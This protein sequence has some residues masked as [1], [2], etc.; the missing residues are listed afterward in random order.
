MKPSSSPRALLAIESTAIARMGAEAARVD[1]L[2]AREVWA[3]LKV[4]DR[5]G[6]S[7]ENAKHCVWRDGFTPDL[8]A[9]V[10]RFLLGKEEVD[11]DILRSR[12]DIDRATWIRGARPSWSDA[13]P[14]RLR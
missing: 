4:P 7:E 6:A 11:T 1:A 13:L 12:F 9:Y 2:A 3:A 5:M 8:E 10:D 14:A